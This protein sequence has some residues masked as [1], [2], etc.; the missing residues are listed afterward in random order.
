MFYNFFVSTVFDT[1]SRRVEV[2][3]AIMRQDVGR[4]VRSPGR[5]AR[6]QVVKSSNKVTPSLTNQ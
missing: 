4:D 6:L 3:A 1:R 2:V 5:R